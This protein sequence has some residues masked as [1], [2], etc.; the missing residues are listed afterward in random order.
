MDG[1]NKDVIQHISDG[2][3][4]TSTN[5]KGDTGLHISAMKGDKDVLQTFITHKV[6]INIRGSGE[7]TP[8]INAAANG[9][10]SCAQLLLAHGA[11]TDLRD[12]FGSTALMYAADENYLDI[13][14]ELLAHGADDK[15]KD[16]ALGRDALKWAEDNKS[17]DAIKILKA[18][19]EQPEEV[20]KKIIAEAK[21][22]SC[23]WSIVKGLIILHPD[24]NYLNKRGETALRLAWNAKYVKLVKLLLDSGAQFDVQ[25]TKGETS[26]LIEQYI[27]KNDVQKRENVI[28]LMIEYDKKRNPDSWADSQH[29]MKEKIKKNVP[30]SG[31]LRDCL[32]SISDKYPWSDGKCKVMLAISF[33]LRVF[34][35]SLL[36]TLDVF[37][38]IQFTLDMYRQANRNFVK[39]LSKCQKTFEKIFDVAIETCK[40]NFDK[41]TCME[42]IDQ[43][44]MY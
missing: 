1:N 14:G 44:E 22:E 19:D 6:D 24:I 17:Q 32:I 16:I 33:I 5:S 38:D 34:R 4:I 27:E 26:L 37:T 36:Y 7:W 21:K 18:R 35:G 40:M 10:L 8:L 20:T 3:E 13:I 12:G 23:N 31:N 30:T 41:I 9:Q 2:A 43:V 28:D 25:N 29:R 42:A 15:I 39:D 11:D